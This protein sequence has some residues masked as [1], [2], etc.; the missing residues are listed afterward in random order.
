MIIYAS[1][2]SKFCYLISFVDCSLH[3]W[4]ILGRDC[5]KKL[6][7]SPT[8]VS[9]L[10]LSFRI[11]WGLPFLPNFSHASSVMS[12]R[13]VS[14]SIE[15]NFSLLIV[16]KQF[17]AW[18]AVFFSVSRFVD[19][20]SNVCSKTWMHWRFRSANFTIVSIAEF[21]CNFFVPPFFLSKLDRYCTQSKLKV[22]YFAQP[23]IQPRSVLPIQSESC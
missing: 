19:V 1:H 11:L 21:P 16:G 10:P 7:A 20:F 13:A 2:T 12:F 23:C 22:V 15:S 5:Q 9:E 8:A 3:Y 6:K 14:V 17:A 18:K 4:D